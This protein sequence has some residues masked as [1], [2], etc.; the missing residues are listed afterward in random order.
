[1]ITDPSQQMKANAAQ[2]SA[3][4][5]N[6]ESANNP[7]RKLIVSSSRRELDLPALVFS[8]HGAQLEHAE[9]AHARLEPHRDHIA[10]FATLGGRAWR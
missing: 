2:P 1:V 4:W 8:G 10:F 6:V 7:D 9:V 3:P 5:V